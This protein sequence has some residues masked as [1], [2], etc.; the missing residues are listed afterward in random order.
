MPK[1]GRT[2]EDWL[3]DIVQWGERMAGYIAG[4]DEEAFKSDLEKQD[5]VIR[6]LECIGEASRH[7]ET[8]ER[9]HQFSELELAEAYWTRNRVIHGY[10]DLDPSRV[11]ATATISAAKLVQKARLLLAEKAGSASSNDLP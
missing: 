1:P 9:A 10:Y 6:C 5:A 3:A 7:L 4:V 8:S 11:F 2:E